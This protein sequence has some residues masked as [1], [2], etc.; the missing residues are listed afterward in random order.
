M[1]VNIPGTKSKK[2]GTKNLQAA[3]YEC[4]YDNMVCVTFDDLNDPNQVLG[5]NLYYSDA[6]FSASDLENAFYRTYMAAD[7]TRFIL[8]L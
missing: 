6:E 4:E 1:N 3:T 2:T 7:E 8:D 5:Y